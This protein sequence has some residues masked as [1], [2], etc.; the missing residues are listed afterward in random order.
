MP[1]FEVRSRMSKMVLGEVV[2]ET[3]DEVVNALLDV[4]GSSI[5]DLA[6]S[7]GGTMEEAVATLDIVEVRPA[8][9][10]FEKH[11]A[12]RPLAKAVFARQRT[13]YAEQ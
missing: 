4:T 6:A 7:L 9:P 13:L 8:G 11:Q 1:T 2:V 12:T 5:E 3:H 10:I